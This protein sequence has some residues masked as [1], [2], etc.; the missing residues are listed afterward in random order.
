MHLK[1]GLLQYKINQLT[2][3][4]YPDVKEYEIWRSTNSGGPYYKVAS[5]DSKKYQHE[6]NWFP[7]SYYFVMT[8]R[9]RYGN[10]SLQSNE[11]SYILKKIIYAGQNNPGGDIDSASC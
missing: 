6:L 4:S 9:D 7:G 1:F 10:R 5:A 11:I 2:W 3:I 8:C